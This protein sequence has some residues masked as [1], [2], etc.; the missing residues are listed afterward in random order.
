MVFCWWYLT[1]GRLMIAV[2]GAL[3]FVPV[4]L[5]SRLSG[6]QGKGVVNPVIGDVEIIVQGEG[7]WGRFGE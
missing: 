7:Q 5:L 2:I 3:S 6:L 1:F 4:L